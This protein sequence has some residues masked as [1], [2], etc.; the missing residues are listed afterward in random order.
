V[1]CI[2]SN[3]YA[4]SVPTV[5]DS[6]PPAPATSVAL[7]LLSP[8]FVRSSPASSLWRRRRERYSPELSLL[9]LS[10]PARG[11][12][13]PL[14]SA[15][16]YAVDDRGPALQDRRGRG[17]TPTFDAH[18]RA[19]SGNE[20]SL[21]PSQMSTCLTCTS[22]QALC[23]RAWG[24]ERNRHSYVTFAG[25]R[26][27]A[28]ERCANADSTLPAGERESE[29]IVSQRAWPRAA[30]HLVRDELATRRG[31]AFLTRFKW[32]SLGASVSKRAIRPRYSL[33]AGWLRPT[34]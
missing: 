3:A 13:I 10:S 4:P 14:S 24:T 30:G 22:G 1:R 27:E 7:A 16:R 17:L 25:G 33:A 23:S 28:H 12:E 32:A 29:I 5:A 11:L 26:R 19:T 21:P 34:P 18:T 8:I 20:T 9:A 6:G 31:A 15:F 2:T